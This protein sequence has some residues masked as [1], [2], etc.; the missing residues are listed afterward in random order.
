MAGKSFIDGGK[1]LNSWREK[2]SILGTQ[3]AYPKK[4]TSFRKRTE[5]GIIDGSHRPRKLSE[6]PA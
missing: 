3:S 5:K 2:Q 4:Y 6:Q 1:I